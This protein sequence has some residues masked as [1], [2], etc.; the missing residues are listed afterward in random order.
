MLRSA[1]CSLALTRS[2]SGSGVL[3]HR[4]ACSA[5][6]DEPGADGRGSLAAAGYPV[7]RARPLGLRYAVGCAE[8][9]A[10]VS[11][12]TGLRASPG[13]P[14]PAASRL[15]GPW[16]AESIVGAPLLPRRLSPAPRLLLL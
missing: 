14:A 9:A 1:A 4:G 11:V 5:M 8:R 3:E 16:L 13:G 10:D 6:Y 2:W 15:V 7:A 12:T